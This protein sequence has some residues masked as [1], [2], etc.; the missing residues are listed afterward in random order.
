MCIRDDL[1]LGCI[2]DRLHAEG[3]WHVNVYTPDHYY[4]GQRTPKEDI[5]QIAEVAKNHSAQHVIVP[6][7]DFAGRREEI[8]TRI[9]NRTLELMAQC[10]QWSLNRNC[11]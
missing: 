4:N 3:V 2:I 9:P 8:E 10:F 11:G 5:E 1:H 7:Q 6:V